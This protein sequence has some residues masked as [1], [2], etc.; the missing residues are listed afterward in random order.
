MTQ[1]PNAHETQ[2]AAEALWRRQERLLSALRSGA[3]DDSGDGRYRDVFAALDR[4]SLPTLSAG[5][6]VRV[7]A[8]AQRLADARAQVS[9][10]KTMLASLLSLLYLPA[11]LAVTLIYGVGLLQSL[12]SNPG[13]WSWVAVSTA[14]AIVLSSFDRLMRRGAAGPAGA[15]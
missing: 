1:G 10:F 4:E 8:D 14:L 12:Q 7:A 3:N 11:M 9:R 2:D 15:R 13:S 6:A 5:F